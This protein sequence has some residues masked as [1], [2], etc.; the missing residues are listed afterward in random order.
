VAINYPNGVDTFNEPSLPEYTSLSSA[1]TGTRAHVEH[2]HD[3][4]QAVVAL[5]NNAAKKGHNH[6][7][8]INDTS[9]GA[10]LDWSNTHESDAPA[11]TLAAARAY[12]DTDTSSLS[13]HHTLGTE[14]NQAAP[15]NHNHTYN[16]LLGIPIKACTDNTRP[17]DPSAGMLIYETNTNRMRV[18]N[19]FAAN[20][21][22]TGL[23]SIENFSAGVNN[24]NLG[25]S[26]WQQT[27]YATDLPVP[28]IFT[29]SPPAP[30]TTEET[31][32]GKMAIPDG[33]T[34]SWIDAGIFTEQCVARRINSADANT[35]TDNQVLSF[36]TG[37]TVI[38]DG[39]SNPLLR[40]EGA[41]N[42]F[43][44]R[45]SAN[46]QSY[47]RFRLGYNYIKVFATTTGRSGEFFI[48]QIS[49]IT[50]AVA[51]TEWRIELQDRTLRFYRLGEFLGAVTDSRAVTSLGQNF[52][53]WGIGMQAG[54]RV[55]GQTTPANLQW[56]RIADLG[57]YET[58]YRWTLLPAASVPSCRLRQS[59][60]QKLTNTGTIL[61]WGGT[62]EED[63]FGFFNSANPSQV[64]ITEPGLYQ[65]EAALQWD[66][67]S[68]PDVASAILMR[69]GTDTDIREQRFIRGNDSIPGFSQTVSLSAKIR[70]AAGDTLAIK[71]SYS[72]KSGMEIFSFFESLVNNLSGASTKVTSR[73]DVTYVAP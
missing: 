57:L 61:Q 72:T 24:N 26:L 73:L 21:L 5:Q 70:A 33:Q 19:S 71:A 38:E 22:T 42:D 53:G 20:Q 51:N 60:A 4:G 8:D 15:G 7:G 2:H 65:V 44:L 63:N 23:N 29:T 46:S 17:L 45:M 10:R 68:C 30:W 34:A 27:Y 59:T 55:L 32:Q 66:P 28:E 13:I 39:D 48:G 64:T 16:N 25:T 67:Q 56:V 40:V 58:I 47:W 14:A 1:G 41:T 31:A 3:L 6:S 54:Y 49:N 9:E 35:Q 11:S 36:K 69:N 12:A 52:R 37:S 62:P 18:W 50:T 43:Y